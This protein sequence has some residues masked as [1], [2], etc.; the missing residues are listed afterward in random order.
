MQSGAISAFSAGANRRFSDGA[1]RRCSNGANQ[2]SLLVL[3][4]F[5]TLLK[6]SYRPVRGA[7]CHRGML[8]PPHATTASYLMLHLI[9]PIA[10]TY[11]PTCLPIY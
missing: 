7:A 11:Q 6:Y 3:A 8:L 5:S 9:P 4:L 2:R 10:A 1:N